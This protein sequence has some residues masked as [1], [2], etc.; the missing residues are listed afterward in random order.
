MNQN[1]SQGGTADPMPSVEP[2]ATPLVEKPTSDPVVQSGTVTTP[3]NPISAM[4]ETTDEEDN[5][6][7]A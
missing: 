3:P 6:Q 1:D 4:A 2:T 7:N 5:G